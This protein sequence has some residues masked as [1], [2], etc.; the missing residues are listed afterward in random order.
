MQS[1]E[2]RRSGGRGATAQTTSWP[3][4]PLDALRDRGDH[5]R[6]RYRECSPP[7]V[8]TR[9]IACL[10]TRSVEEGTTPAT[11]RIVPDGCVDVVWLSDATLMVAGPDT[12]PVISHLPP[13]ATVIG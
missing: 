13:G 5:A 4:S 12:G 9:H 3:P 2:T 8:L 11:T 6:N 1:G 7:A 10:W